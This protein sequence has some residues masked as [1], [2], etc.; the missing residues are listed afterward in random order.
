MIA[1]KPTRF[2]RRWCVAALLA[3]SPTATQAVDFVDPNTSFLSIENFYYLGGDGNLTRYATAGFYHP[4][5]GAVPPRFSMLPRVRLDGANIVAINKQGQKVAIDGINDASEISV[6]NI[7]VSYRGTLPNEMEGAAIWSQINGTRLERFLPS[8]L[9]HPNGQPAIY[10]PAQF[11]PLAGAVIQHTNQY[12]Q[13]VNAQ[14]AL[15][16]SWKTVRA[17]VANMDSL[18]VKLM[19]NGE[20][21]ASRAMQGAAILASGRFPSLSVREPTLEYLNRLREGT[22]EVEINYNFKD[23]RLGSVA[24]SYDYAAA[25]SNYIEETQRA[26]TRSRSSGWS[27]FNIGSRR[28]SVRQHVTQTARQNSSYDQRT[29]TVVEIEDA[30]DLLISQFESQFFPGLSR[31]RAI[32]EHTEAAQLAQSQG[33]QPLADAHMKYVEALTS[34]DRQSEIDAIGAA[35]ALSSGNYAMFIAKGVRFQNSSTSQASSFYRVVSQNVSEGVG[36]TWTGTKST[37]VKRRVAV[38]VT[39]DDKKRYKAWLGLYDGAPL[40]TASGNFFVPTCILAGGPLH[41]SGIQQGMLIAR[42]DGKTIKTIADLQNVLSNRE[43]G[44]EIEIRAQSQQNPQYFET[45]YVKLA[46]GEMLDGPM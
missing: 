23:S 27:I 13:Q 6:I 38:L 2:V 35:A 4:Q 15:V 11:S 1:I 40:Q 14:K 19:L 25:M 29:N 16:D 18:E 30:D 5:K 32:Q 28:S 45:Y 22:Y 44:E 3:L 20:I 36:K 31:E 37:S 42:I 26:I 10:P 41:K 17:E 34:G 21:I 33:N 7:P 24:A 43:P 9:V 12:M 46:R 39:P 8:A